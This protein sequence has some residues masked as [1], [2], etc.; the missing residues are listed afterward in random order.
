MR[1]NYV[2]DP[3]NQS[4]RVSYVLAPI[5]G[6]DDGGY[7]VDPKKGLT[8]VTAIDDYTLEVKLRYPFA[9][10]FQ[11]LGHPVA[12]AWPVDY[13]KEIGAKAFAAKPVGT[14]PYMVESW[15]NNQAVELAKNPDYWNKDAA[16]YVDNIHMP[17]IAESQTVWLE[18][19]KGSLDY[20]VVPP[21]QVAAAEANP[22]VKSGE[23]SAKAWPNLAVYFIGM[24]M[25]DA[26]LGQN[27]ELRKAIAMSA[28]SQNVINIVNEG[29]SLPAT[30][31]VPE[32]IPGYRADQNP[33]KYDPA[34][35]NDGAFAA[36]RARSGVHRVG[37]TARPAG[38]DPSAARRPRGDPRVVHRT[39]H[40]TGGRPR[41]RVGTTCRTRCAIRDQTCPR[42]SC[43][44]SGVIAN[45]RP[46]PRPRD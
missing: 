27:L 32:G 6:N 14:G 11:T 36:H 28:D 10:F 13:A 21:G 34:G 40:A 39:A 18:F 2:T 16:G 31:Y 30:G 4:L 38:S 17:I 35:A 23:W 43:R 15:K 44:A 26:A 1:W 8:G 25:T 19:Q 3:K 45:A 29:V 12:S 41:V 9:E 7:Q 37:V 33:Y 42:Q 46:P 20:S 5:E 22:K 24:N